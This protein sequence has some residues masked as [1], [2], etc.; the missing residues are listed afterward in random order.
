PGACGHWC[1]IGNPNVTS[2]GRALRFYA[3]G[4]IEFR[5][6]GKIMRKRNV[7]R[8]GKLVKAEVTTGRWIQVRVEKDKS[9]RPGRE[10][11]FVFD[12]GL[13]TIDPGWEL[14]SLGLEDGLVERNSTG[15]YSYEDLEG[16]V[17]K[18]TEKKFRAILRDKPEI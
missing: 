7:V 12:Y 11:S 8:S 14:I 4:R 2:G 16:V 1:E 9:T 6:G 10:G 13:K 5:R 15:I 17:W 18:G 3:T